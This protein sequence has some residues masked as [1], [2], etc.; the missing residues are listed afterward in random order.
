M[1]R[2]PSRLVL[3]DHG[4]PHDPWLGVKLS[5]E[6]RWRAFFSYEQGLVPF[7]DHGVPRDVLDPPHHELK[8][9]AGVDD[10]TRSEHTLLER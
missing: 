10:I 3:G 2:S 4:R 5:D 9:N 1:E 6:H 7:N 8:V